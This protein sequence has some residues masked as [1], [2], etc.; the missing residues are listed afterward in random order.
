M[1]RQESREDGSSRTPEETECL[2][3]VS[4]PPLPDPVAGSEITSEPAP[5]LGPAAAP[6]AVPAPN[7][8]PHFTTPIGTTSVSMTIGISANESPQVVCARILQAIEQMGIDRATAVITPVDRFLFQRVSHR[9]IAR[10]RRLAALTSQVSSP[11]PYHVDGGQ[12]DDPRRWLSV[13][14]IA[15]PIPEL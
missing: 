4:A 10:R 14:E 8:G 6:A 12:V 7:A 2:R 3:A 13:G 9:Q 5:T 1:P 11:R 15:R